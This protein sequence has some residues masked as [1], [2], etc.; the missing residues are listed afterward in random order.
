MADFL[1]EN[2]SPNP[3]NNE[4]HIRVRFFNPA[5]ELD[6]HASRDAAAMFAAAVASTAAVTIDADITPAMPLLPCARLWTVPDPPWRS[7][8][9]PQHG[10]S[11]LIG[12]RP[13]RSVLR[14]IS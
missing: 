14:R 10:D 5:I 1:S 8:P 9:H 11:P 7:E 13:P 2:P 3:N 12:D 6:Y 4:C